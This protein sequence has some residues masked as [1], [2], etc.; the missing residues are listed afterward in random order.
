[1]IDLFGLLSIIGICPETVRDVAPRGVF[2]IEAMG[3]PM[4]LQSLAELTSQTKS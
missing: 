3:I 4:G 1:M 2:E